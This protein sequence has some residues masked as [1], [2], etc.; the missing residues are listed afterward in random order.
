[1]PRGIL[2]AMSS[3][4]GAPRPNR[5]TIIPGRKAWRRGFATCLPIYGSDTDPYRVLIVD[6]DLTHRDR[7]E[8]AL[9][10]RGLAVETAF[11]VADALSKGGFLAAPDLV[12]LETRYRD[13]SGLELMRRLQER[14]KAARFIFVLRAT[15]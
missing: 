11:G 7:L 8:R 12:V 2:I 3:E 10:E 1:M 6:S 4:A 13:G 5:S 9:L 15:A 14:W